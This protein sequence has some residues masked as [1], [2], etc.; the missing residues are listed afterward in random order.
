MERRRVV[1]TGMGTINPVGN[2]VEEAWKNAKNG[3]GGIAKIERF[4]TTGSEVTF[5]GEVKNFD[6]KAVF[7]HREARRMDR[8]TAFAMMAA[9]EALKDSGLKLETEDPYDVGVLIGSGIGGIESLLD[10]AKLGWE[11]GTRFISPLLIP[12]MLTDSPSGRVAL[13]Y[14]LRGPNMSIS[15]ACATG[16]NSIG[17]ALEMIRRGSAEVMLTGSVE[18]ALVPLALASF[19]NMTTLSRRND[20]PEH[21]SRP[22]DKDRD[23][24]VMAEGGAVLVIEE[25][26]HAIQRGAH[27]YAEILGYGNTDDAF[28]YTAP[29]ENGEAAGRAMRKAIKDAA[30]GLEEIDYINAH[31]TSTPLNDSS[32][33]RAIK[34]VWGEKAYDIPISSTKGVTGHILGGAGSVEAVFSVKAIQEQFVP[35]TANLTTPDPDCDLNYVPIKGIPHKIDKVMSN[36]FGFGGHNAVLIFGAYHNGTNGTR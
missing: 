8:V 24:F 1:I 23:G 21:A 25:L 20:D 6:P 19:N 34:S 27:I 29:M 2:S 35:P 26:Q 16:N 22:F 32:E 10:Q 18:A 12:I 14:G 11:K 17:E 13:E 7:G 33:T 30:I 5:A 15:T 4:D 3:L 31:G 9:A 36:S 28:H